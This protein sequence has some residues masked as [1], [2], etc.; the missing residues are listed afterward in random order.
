MKFNEKTLDSS[1]YVREGH[2]ECERELC[3]WYDK[4]MKVCNR[5]LVRAVLFP[6]A[7]GARRGR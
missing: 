2:C 1:G 6:T 5:G 7:S 3:M 4:D